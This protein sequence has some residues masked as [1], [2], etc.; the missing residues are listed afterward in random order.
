MLINEGLFVGL[1]G[2]TFIRHVHA[3]VAGDEVG[4]REPAIRAHDPTGLGRPSHLQAAT[5]PSAADTGR[6][7]EQSGGASTDGGQEVLVP[8]PPGNRCAPL[9]AEQRDAYPAS[10]RRI[11][12]S[13]FSFSW[14]A[15][16][17]QWSVWQEDGRSTET[18][19]GNEGT[20]Y[21][22]ASKSS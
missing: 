9:M 18:H 7:P 17:G 13:Q 11:G 1:D 12:G 22:I 15:F 6:R 2:T 4:S 20:I 21:F 3:A 10:R 5:P 14:L 8:P 19:C 16:Y